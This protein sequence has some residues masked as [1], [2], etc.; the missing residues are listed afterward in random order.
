MAA[1]GGLVFLE[2]K[3]RHVFS[4]KYAVVS[5][6]AR[7]E[8]APTLSAQI[9]TAPIIWWH[10][11]RLS[12]VSPLVNLLVLPFV[13]PLMLLGSIQLVLGWVVAPF[14]YALLHLI[15]VI[16]NFFG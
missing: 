11:G 5:M 12:L 8:L 15:V 16:I 6:L 3:I 14:S 9:M 1:T 2:P 7:T 13:P 4:S 10:F